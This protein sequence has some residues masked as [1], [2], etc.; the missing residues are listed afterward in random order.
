MNYY[1][2]SVHSV[3]GE[4]RPP[5]TPEEMEAFA[6][7]I[8][9][10]QDDMKATGAFVFTGALQEASAA[11][12]VR[13]GGGGTMVTDGPFAESKEHVGGFYVLTVED[14]AAALA[15]AERVVDAIGAPIEVREFRHAQEE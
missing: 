3:D 12:V 7:R 14:H 9:A 8:D 4:D 1:M 2:L 6:A 15:W 11:T 13:K 10:L 5:P